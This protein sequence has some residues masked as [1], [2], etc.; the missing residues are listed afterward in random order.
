MPKTT[1]R[2]VS[3]TRLIKPTVT[4]I[5]QAQV[6][7]EE[8]IVTKTVGVIDTS[9]V[10]VIDTN[11]IQQR[12]LEDASTVGIIDTNTVEIVETNLAVETPLPVATVIVQTDR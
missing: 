8:V 11:A 3:R 10:G 4:V 1:R 6:V 2:T 9:T 12:M 5:K 7:N